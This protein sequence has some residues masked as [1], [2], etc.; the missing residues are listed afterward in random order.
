MGSS[1]SK[2]MRASLDINSKSF[3]T[4]TKEWRVGLVFPLSYFQDKEKFDIIRGRQ[5]LGLPKG[6]GYEEDFEDKSQ[7]GVNIMLRIKN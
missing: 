2:E 5:H 1:S 3:S 7:A 4:S 6:L